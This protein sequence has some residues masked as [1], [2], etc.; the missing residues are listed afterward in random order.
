MNLL[1]FTEQELRGG[2][3]LLTDFRGEHI[4]SVLALQP[5]DTVR[6][7]MINGKLGQGTVL[8]LDAATVRLAVRLEREP[9]PPPPVEL[10]LALPR[11][12]MLQRILKQ[13]ATLGVARI[14]LIR[15]AKVEKSFFHSPALLPEKITERLLEGLTQAAADTRLPEVRLHPQFKIFMEDVLPTL[16]GKG[17]LAHPGV[18]TTLPEVAS[19][20]Q[21]RGNILLAIG[22]E[23]GWN[24]F[25]LRSFVE[26]NFAAFSMGSRILHVDTA[27]AV[28]LG[29]L[30]LL[31]SLNGSR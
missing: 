8:S 31:R 27:A 7:G 28:L 22:P 12:I 29:Q 9:P 10:I 16:T 21:C 25:E 4:R 17:L 20:D 11:P 1:L 15:S 13:A 30:M 14:H 19:S 2:E 18:P 5:G 24:D 23:G 6:L 3:L 26:Q